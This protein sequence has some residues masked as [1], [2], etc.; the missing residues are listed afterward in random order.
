MQ[1]KRAGIVPCAHSFLRTSRSQKARHELSLHIDPGACR[2]TTAGRQATARRLANLIALTGKG[3]RPAMLISDIFQ[4]GIRMQESVRCTRYLN[5]SEG[6]AL[7][8][9]TRT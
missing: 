1:R 5:W 2:R 9:S 7:Q 3:K 8:G 4:Q 6:T